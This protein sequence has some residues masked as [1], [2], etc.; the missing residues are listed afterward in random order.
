MST[1]K[2]KKPR[3]RH[4]ESARKGTPEHARKRKV[5]SLRLSPELRARLEARALTRECTPATMAE[6][7]IE[8]GLAGT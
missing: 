2:Q 1:T 7:L 4:A 8:A 3:A 5:L 6:A